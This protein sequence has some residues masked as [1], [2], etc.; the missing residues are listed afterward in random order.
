[1]PAT[2]MRRVS[3]SGLSCAS[4]GGNIHTTEIGIQ[5][6]ATTISICQGGT[7]AL[8]ENGFQ[9]LRWRGAKKTKRPPL[10]AAVRFIPIIVVRIFSSL[11]GLAATYSSKSS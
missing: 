1:M 8:V 2:S 4:W 3:A 6:N 7:N 11:A 9:D 5:I 10:L